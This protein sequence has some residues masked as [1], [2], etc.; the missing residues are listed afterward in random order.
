MSRNP[1]SVTCPRCD[2]APYVKCVDLRLAG[3][4]TKASP[5][6]ERVTKAREG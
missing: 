3:L 1:L 4:A 5:H 2:A 6:R